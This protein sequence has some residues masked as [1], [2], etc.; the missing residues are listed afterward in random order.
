MTAFRSSA[1]YHLIVPPLKGQAAARCG[2]ACL[3]LAIA[4]TANAASAATTATATTRGASLRRIRPSICPPSPTVGAVRPLGRAEFLLVGPSCQG[5]RGDRQQTLQIG[6][7][8]SRLV[9]GAS[10][11]KVGPMS[12]GAA[13]DRRLTYVRP[14]RGRRAFE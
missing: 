13:T 4:V 1:M 2:A 11:S 3:P 12:E 9:R 14:V 10:A 6:D 8:D 7:S 5:G